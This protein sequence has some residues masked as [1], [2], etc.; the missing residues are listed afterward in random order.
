MSFLEQ[1][2]VRPALGENWSMV[3]SHFSVVFYSFCPFLAIIITPG[4]NNLLQILIQSSLRRYCKKM[5]LVWIG[6]SR[7][8]LTQSLRIFINLVCFILT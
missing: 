7:Q 6:I 2:H 8:V 5:S 4:S 3:A 1:A